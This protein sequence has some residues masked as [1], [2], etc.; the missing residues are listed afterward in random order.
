MVRCLP[1]FSL[2]CKLWRHFSVRRISTVTSFWKAFIAWLLYHFYMVEWFYLLNAFCG[3][4]T[5]T[6]RGKIALKEVFRRRNLKT[7]SVH[8]AKVYS[9][10]HQNSKKNVYV[11]KEQNQAW[12]RMKRT[13]KKIYLSITSTPMRAIVAIFSS[14]ASSFPSTQHWSVFH[15]ITPDKPF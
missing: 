1:K 9:R 14:N 4:T 11:K 2:H 8:T 15:I 10:W 13:W 7:A 12:S 5:G 6:L 3:K